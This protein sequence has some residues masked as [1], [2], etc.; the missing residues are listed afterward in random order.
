MNLTLLQIH[1]LN[2]IH[3]ARVAVLGT[4][5]KASSIVAQGP[6]AFTSVVQNKLGIK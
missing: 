3:A 1:A 4:T 5:I 6:K 2:A